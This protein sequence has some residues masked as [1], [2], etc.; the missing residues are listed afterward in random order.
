MTVGGVLDPQ[1][2][3]TFDWPPH[4][5]KLELKRCKNLDTPILEG[6]LYNEQLREKLATLHVHKDN[7]NM[8]SGFGEST[9][10]YS[11]R[12]LTY[13]KIPLDFLES[14]NIVPFRGG[15][16]PLP[17]RILELTS[18]YFA[19]ELEFTFSEDLQQALCQN[20]RNLWALGIGESSLPYLEDV[21]QEIDEEIWKHV[22]ESSDDEL[23]KLAI[24]DLGI[25]TIDDDPMF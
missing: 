11:L 17:L 25:Y 6:I 15:M 21:Y 18:S 3:A 4:L 23:D 13:L 16:D 22:E 20:L 1:I 9:V 2:M 10:L 14:L 19:D 5:N 12:S 24:E 8:F 7:A